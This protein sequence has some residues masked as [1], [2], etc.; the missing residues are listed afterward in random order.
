MAY[1]LLSCSGWATEGGW[2]ASGACLKAR[3][4]IVILFFVIAIIRRWGGEEIGVDFNFMFA[5]LFGLLPYLLVVTI[6]GSFKAAFVIG[7]IGALIGGYGAG[8]F[9]GGGDGE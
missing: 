9:F 6:F 3:I 1:N 5:L 2:V 8:M 7:I 4:G